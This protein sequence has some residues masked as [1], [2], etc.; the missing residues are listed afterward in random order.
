MLYKTTIPAAL[1]AASLCALALP[2]QAQTLT[3]SAADPAY[4]SGY[5]GKNGGSGF[6]PFQVAVSASGG[7]DAGTFLF[8]AAE[9]EDNKGTPA[10]S[11]IDTKSKSFGFY[12]HGSSRGVGNPSVSVT[13]RFTTP[14]TR[15]GDSFSLDFV[16][17]YND[18]GTAGV[19]LTTGSGPVGRFQYQAGGSYY[20]NGRLAVKGY[21]PGALHLTYTLTSPTTYTFTSTGAVVFSGT[22]KTS[23]PITGFLVQQTNASKGN[24][25]AATPD[26]NGYFNNLTL[27]Y[28][29]K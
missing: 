17:G 29:A 2:G 11:T 13:R 25:A 18:G 14:L 3:D 9:G 15:T 28:G 27:K 4:A 12:A 22:G 1:L 21:K 20:F 23:G 24:M 19:A 10:P 16:T 8:T 6:G 26:H 5:D 7:G